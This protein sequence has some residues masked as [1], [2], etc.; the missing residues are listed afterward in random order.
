VIVIAIVIAMMM[1]KIIKIFSK[2]SFVL[3]FFK[4]FLF[5]I[6]LP[7]VENLETGDSRIG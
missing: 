1:S 2:L 4:M 7:R 6:I 5:K 3:R